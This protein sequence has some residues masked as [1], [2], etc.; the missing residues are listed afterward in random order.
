MPIHSKHHLRTLYKTFT[1]NIKCQL[2]KVIFLRKPAG[3]STDQLEEICKTGLR[4]GI[5][6][7]GWGGV[8]EDRKTN[9]EWLVHVDFLH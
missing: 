5:H 1:H 4:V 9:T 7:P 3:S 2:L 6:L 8:G